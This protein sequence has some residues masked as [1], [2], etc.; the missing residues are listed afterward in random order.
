MTAKMYRDE[1][2]KPY[3]R[4]FRGV[5]GPEFNLMDDNTRPQRAL[6]VDEFLESEDIYRMDWPSRS[7]DLNPIERVWDALGRA[8]VNRNPPSRTIQCLK[9]ALLKEWDELPWN[10]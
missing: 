3:A 9:T 1:V 5:V 10:S 4:L 8:I 7:P 2:L 6:L